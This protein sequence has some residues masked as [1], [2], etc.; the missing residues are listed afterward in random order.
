[1][2]KTIKMYHESGLAKILPKPTTED[3]YAQLKFIFNRVAN[4]KISKSTKEN[5]KTALSFY[6]NTYLP[7]THN[8]DS[9]LENNKLFFLNEQ[10]DKFA[11]HN[12]EKYFKKYNVEGSKT[13]LS[14]FT[15]TSHMSAIRQVMEYALFHQLTKDENLLQAGVGLPI[16]ETEQNTAY[17]D[18]E[19]NEINRMLKEEL[20]F[21]SKLLSKKGYQKTGIGRDPRIKPCMK[22]FPRGSVH[23][24]GFGWKE[25]DNMR[26]YFENVMDCEALSGVP[27]NKIKH[28]NFFHNVTR[29]YKGGLPAL[30]RAWGVTSLI[31]ADVL[32]PFA[33][34]LALYTGMNPDSLWDLTADCFQEKHPLSN[35]PY[36]KYFKQRSLGHKEMHLN[37]YDKNVAIRELKENEANVI[38]TIFKQI[39]ELTAAVRERAP[40]ELKSFLFIYEVSSNNNYGVVSRINIKVTSEWCKRKLIRYNL[41]S[42]NDKRLQLNI[43]RFRST[44]ISQMVKEGYDFFEIQ[45]R[46]GHKSIAQTLRYISKNNLEINARKIIRTALTYIHENRAWQLQEQPEYA[47]EHTSSNKTVIYKGIIADCRNVL[48][49]PKEVQM[50]K[51]YQKGEV[52][53]RYN[54]CLFCKNVVILTLHLPLLIVYKNQIVNAI[55]NMP[56]ELPT[57]KHYKKSLSIIEEILDPEKSEFSKEDLE[58]AHSAA[59]CMNELTDTVVY[60]PIL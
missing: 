5:F 2:A 28:N 43:V 24:E 20:E 34:K 25:T 42:Q 16:K 51:G 15:V 41:R 52:C 50:L 22:G 57:I 4:L 26:W 17:S 40:K 33:M 21:T 13:R 11:L 19:V 23:P 29:C 36:I 37:I 39:I 35:V 3:P 60:R 27:E 18:F 56:I 14:S 6:I 46:C 38:R 7:K 45:S 48:D 49:P 32:M 58:W 44:K 1:M 55:K 31:D 12:V 47:L 59:E 10:W 8:F 9:K 54:M 30:Y 53:T